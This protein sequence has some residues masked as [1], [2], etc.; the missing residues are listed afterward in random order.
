MA[1]RR[2]P[3]RPARAGRHGFENHTLDS[4]RIRHAGRARHAGR[5]FG[6]VAYRVGPRF[7]PRGNRP[8]ELTRSTVGPTRPRHTTVESGTRKAGPERLTV[9]HAFTARLG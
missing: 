4:R 6:R 1:R 3:G 7:H 5:T 2:P 8:G 9:Q